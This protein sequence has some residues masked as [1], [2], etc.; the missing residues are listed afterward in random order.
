[1]GEAIAAYLLSVTV[2]ECV[3]IHM[4]FS[5]TDMLKYYPINALTFVFAQD[6]IHRQSITHVSYGIRSIK[7]DKDSLNRFKEGM[8]F[9][10]EFIRERIEV[11]PRLKLFLDCGLARVAHWAS[12]KYCDRS[13]LAENVHGA[14]SIYL[15]QNGYE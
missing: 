4:V 11:N 12:A 7:G 13:E 10:K 3:H 5:R 15:K 9:T 6:A 8:G 14:V 1:M 2:G